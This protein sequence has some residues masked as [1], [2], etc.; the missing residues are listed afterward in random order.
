MSIDPYRQPDPVE[1]TPA[2]KFNAGLN[3]FSTGSTLVFGLIFVVAGVGILL[4]G[5]VSSESFMVPLGA[6]TL[7]LGAVRLLPLLR[8]WRN[9]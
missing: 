1:P 8:R 5:L 4:W 9:R 3:A 7:L 6:I 2:T